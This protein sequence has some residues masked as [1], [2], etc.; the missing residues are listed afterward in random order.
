M[1]FYTYHFFIYVIRFIILYSILNIPFPIFAQDIKSTPPIRLSHTLQ[2]IFIYSDPRLV[3]FQPVD[4]ENDGVDELL[5][6][7]DEKEIKYSIRFHR[8]FMQQV[9]GQANFIESEVAYYDHSLILHFEANEKDNFLCIGTKSD[10]T[11]FLEVYD[12]SLKSVMKIHV[13]HGMDNDGNGSW[14]GEV[15][16]IAAE[17]LNNDGYPDVIAKVTSAYDRL[18]R[19]IW[20]INVKQQNILWKFPTGTDITDVVVHDID[21]DGDF[22]IVFGGAAVGN[23]ASENGTDDEHSYLIILNHKGERVYQYETGGVFSGCFPKVA[24]FRGDGDLKIVTMVRS[25]GPDTPV[26]GLIRV[27]DAQTR[28]IER[29]YPAILQPSKFLL[30]DIDLDGHDEILVGTISVQSELFVFTDSLHLLK[31]ISLQ[32]GAGD[33]LVADLNYD[34]EKEIIVSRWA[35]GNTLVLNSRFE[36]MAEA[37]VGGSL[38]IVHRGFGKPGLLAEI[39]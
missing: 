5:Y 14:D 23:G 19:G 26:S 1:S 36:R 6:L 37:T 34:G 15:F 18:P 22:E 30:S 12:E 32:F 24:D 2:K 33:I 27:R 20:A 31:R 3:K 13:V 7:I 39:L 11:A 9:I 28:S 29:E 8:Q 17:D 4:L 25:R 35:E 10:N 21:S 16:P 38:F